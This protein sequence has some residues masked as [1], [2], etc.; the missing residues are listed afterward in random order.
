VGL[1]EF[2]G[3][4]QADAGARRAGRGAA[5]PEPLEDVR[6]LIGGDAR[7]GVGDGELRTV[8]GRAGG[9]DDVPAGWGELDRVGEQ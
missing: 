4:G 5:A 1:G 7:A 3:H 2:G 6:Q 9:E 8:G